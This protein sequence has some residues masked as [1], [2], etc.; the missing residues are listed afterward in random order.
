MRTYNIYH[1]TIPTFNEDVDQ[2]R[3]YEGSIRAKSLEDAYIKSQN[4]TEEGWNPEMESRSTSV[5]DLI[6]DEESGELF[7]VMNFG[8]KLLEEEMTK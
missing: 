5:G 4:L 6:E 8:F 3:D 1:C 7:M 2:L